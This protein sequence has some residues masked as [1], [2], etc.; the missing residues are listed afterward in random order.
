[1]P[2]PPVGG[3][4]PPA[5]LVGV[6]LGPLVVEDLLACGFRAVRPMAALC[7]VADLHPDDRRWNEQ[8]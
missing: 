5:I 2:L 1:M 7:P 4:V 6:L 8:F 3:R